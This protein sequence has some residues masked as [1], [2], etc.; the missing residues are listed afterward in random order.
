[1]SKIASLIDIYDGNA[2]QKLACEL[3]ILKYG[4]GGFQ[5]VPDQHSGDWGIE[6]FSMAGDAFQ[7]YSPKKAHPTAHQAAL[8]I[9]K[10]KDDIQKFIDN[11]D[12]LA[13]LVPEGRYQRWFFLTT[14]FESKLLPQVCTEMSA[15]VIDECD[16]VT[17]DFRVIVHDADEFFMNEIPQYV[18]LGR[19]LIRLQVPDIPGEAIEDHVQNSDHFQ[20]ISGKLTTAN[21]AAHN[22]PKLANAYIKDFL[23]WK[24][25]MGDIRSSAP[26]LF[27]LIER[28]VTSVEQDVIKKY[29]LNTD[30]TAN[31]IQEELTSLKKDLIHE[32]NAL[33]D[34]TTIDH[35]S[36]GV[37][38]DWLIR[39][40]I[41]F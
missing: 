13:T 23:I 15:K 25:M 36:R 12:E 17:D 26:D 29:Q 7:C 2:W 4:V 19:N 8:Q 11:E 1:M 10:I 38:A 18:T 24:T 40:P 21:V 37:V 32:V 35:L 41:S 31:E 3:L 5:K 33:I 27:E 28:K 20:V 22:V 39:C 6:G 30:M 14:V 16:H 9:K 34:S